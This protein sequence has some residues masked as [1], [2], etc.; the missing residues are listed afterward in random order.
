MGLHS[1]FSYRP[2]RLQAAGLR[3]GSHTGRRPA[4]AQFA[5]E[6]SKVWS[7]AIAPYDGYVLVTANYNGGPP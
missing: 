6:H 3:R 1:L 5:H 4:Y 7:A 2:C